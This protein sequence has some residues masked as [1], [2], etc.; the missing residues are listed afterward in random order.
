[1]VW[2]GSV[3]Y[4]GFFSER[5]GSK[6]NSAIHFEFKIL[7]NLYLFKQDWFLR[8]YN[9]YTAE[10]SGGQQRFLIRPWVRC[11]G[12]HL[13]LFVKW[14]T[15]FWPPSHLKRRTVTGEF[16]NGRDI[17]RFSSASSF[18]GKQVRKRR[19]TKIT[20]HSY[21]NENFPKHIWIILKYW[22]I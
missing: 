6:P 18:C 13:E 22:I 5:E 17:A 20:Q 15:G 7:K 8:I 4:S 19:I 10:V 9:F 3:A 12:G 1:M 16:C 2:I 11:S 14:S 21:I